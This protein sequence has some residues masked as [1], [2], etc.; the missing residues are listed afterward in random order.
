MLL[1]NLSAKDILSM[2]M[3]KIKSIPGHFKLQ[4]LKS[5]T[6]INLIQLDIIDITNNHIFILA[7]ELQLITSIEHLLIFISPNQL[8]LIVIFNFNPHFLDVN[9]FTEPYRANCFRTGMLFYF[10]S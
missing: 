6:E 2:M 9:R 5:I 10:Y 4:Q 7:A 1:L 8:V 3:I